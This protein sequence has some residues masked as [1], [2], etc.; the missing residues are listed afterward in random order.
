MSAPEARRDYLMNRLLV[1]AEQLRQLLFEDGVRGFGQGRTV[2]EDNSWHALR[3]FIDFAHN[4]CRFGILFDVNVS[5]WDTHRLEDLARAAAV[6]APCGRI[7]LDF[8]G[9]N[10]HVTYMPCYYMFA[11]VG[12]E[13]LHHPFLYKV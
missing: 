2:G 9:W 10:A 13:S 4:L 7:E 1:G 6:A 11:G 8:S 12:R 3:A 5:V